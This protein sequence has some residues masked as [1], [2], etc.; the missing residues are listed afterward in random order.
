MHDPINRLW[1]DFGNALGLD[2]LALDESGYC[3]LSAEP[4]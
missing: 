1:T 2:G 3:C 4:W